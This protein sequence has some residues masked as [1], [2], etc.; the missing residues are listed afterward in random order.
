MGEPSRLSPEVH[1]RPES[2][3]PY[4]AEFRHQ[5]IDLVRAGLDPEDP[6]R[7]FQLSGLR[8][9]IGLPMSTERKN[10][11][12]RR[13]LLRPSPNATICSACGAR[14]SSCG[15]TATF[16]LEPR[17]IRSRSNC[18]ADLRSGAVRVFE[19]MS[20]NQAAFPIATMARVLGVS[21]AGYHA[22]HGRPPSAHPLA[23]A[24]PLKRVRTLHA[25]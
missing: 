17:L 5:T 8:S 23:D 20:A 2:R 12:K 7:E 25:S 22:W 13:L 4:S 9:A 11:G 21:E 10:F 18:G 6:S 14:T 1:A 3:P 15:R 19:F 24:A 16:S